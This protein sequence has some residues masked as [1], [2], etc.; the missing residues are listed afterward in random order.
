VTSAKKATKPSR[1]LESSSLKGAWAEDLA[2][3]H[4]EQAGLKVL[5]RNYRIRGGEI[6]LIAQDAAGVTVFLEVK[7]RGSDSH[8]AAGEFITPRKA[9]LVRHAALH[10]LGRDDLPC[11]FDAVLVEGRDAVTARVQWLQDAF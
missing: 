8:G 5:A 9:E 1:T 11:R 7:Q 6:D 3:A 4:L 2:A 10:Y